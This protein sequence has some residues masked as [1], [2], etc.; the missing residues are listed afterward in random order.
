MPTSRRKDMT[1]L[2]STKGANI[3]DM[4]KGASTREFFGYLT[5]TKG[6]ER[7]FESK[8]PH[9]ATIKRSDHRGSLSKRRRE[10]FSKSFIKQLF[11]DK[12]TRTLIA[13]D[14]REAKKKQ[15]LTEPK[16]K[17][18]SPS[19]VGERQRSMIEIVEGG[20]RTPQEYDRLGNRNK[21]QDFLREKKGRGNVFR[22]NQR[23]LQKVVGDIGEEWKTSDQTRFFKKDGS[24][25]KAFAHLPGGDLTRSEVITNPG[26]RSPWGDA[27]KQNQERANAFRAVYQGAHLGKPGS[28][29][30]AR[31]QHMAKNI[32]L[33]G[34]ASI[35]KYH[36]Q[37]ATEK[38]NISGKQKGKDLIR[39]LKKS[40][41]LPT[42]GAK[43]KKSAIERVRLGAKNPL[44]R[45]MAGQQ[46]LHQAKDRLIA[47]IKGLNSPEKSWLLKSAEGI[48]S[49]K[50]VEKVERR[51]ALV[52]SAGIAVTTPWQVRGGKFGPGGKFKNVWSGG[53]V[54]N[55][56]MVSAGAASIL[57]S[58]PEFADATSQSVLREAA[59]GVTPKVVTAPQLKSSTN[60]G[61]AV[62]NQEQEG[63]R[64]SV[65][66]KLHGIL[67]PKQGASHGFIPSY[68]RTI[69]SA[70]SAGG[71]GTFYR[72]PSPRWRDNRG[73][74]T[75]PNA[76]Q[77]ASRVGDI[78]SMSKAQVN[79]SG[80]NAMEHHAKN[81][82]NAFRATGT[83]LKKMDPAV[84]KAAHQFKNVGMAAA[85]AAA[86]TRGRKGI[87][88]TA[89]Q[90]EFSKQMFRRDAATQMAAEKGKHAGLLST[91]Q[92]KRGEL[93]ETKLRNAI[94]TASKGGVGTKA[95]EK[96][97]KS[98]DK[99]ISKRALASMDQPRAFANIGLKQL[100]GQA[101]ADRMKERQVTG[102]FGERQMQKHYASRYM[103]S[104]GMEGMTSKGAMRSID[105]MGAT[106]RQDFAQ[107]MSSQGVMD[108]SKVFAAGKVSFGEFDRKFG[109]GSSQTPRRNKLGQFK[110]ARKGLNAAEQK[111]QRA[112][113]K[114]W[115]KGIGKQKG[116]W[117]K[118]GWT[119]GE[120]ENGSG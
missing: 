115:T 22:E 56:G 80:L 28:A 40:L 2:P 117:G 30:A 62:V 77:L 61:L 39:D 94:T 11:A 51:M 75:S 82:T 58:Q 41:A 69:P 84:Q 70:V 65:A 10:A 1:G 18:L 104:L 63:G 20:P 102:G 91:L 4:L 89:S 5:A 87:G 14:M 42:F 86:Q 73:R 36:A 38:Q 21:R 78:K 64:L 116:S 106:G 120:R 109:I 33:P 47:E 99:S 101:I 29:E 15:K 9:E 74:F 3:K 50:D 107:Y 6:Y 31:V 57:R 90:R 92:N 35:S 27:M 26:A 97:L 13:N 55:Y 81:L 83:S 16:P 105:K 66:K 79:L 68:A 23:M 52:R 96:Q 95:L 60:P 37:Q 76:A 67:D 43:L 114:D 93:S 98:L 34:I 24:P 72:D 19:N 32:A 45:N 8:L 48:N 71:Q 103:A 108:K 53:F 112:A 113:M 88:G 12:E 7:G 17:P 59:H 44:E 85:E 49:Y 46:I 25:R 118:F 110:T 111:A 119:G 100:K 54:P